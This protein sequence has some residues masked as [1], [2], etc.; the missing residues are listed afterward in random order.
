MRGR[1]TTWTRIRVNLQHVPSELRPAQEPLDPD[2]DPWQDRNARQ[3][4]AI[5]RRAEDLRELVRRRD[6]ELVVAAVLGRLSGRQRR[7]IAAWR[8]RCPAD[9]RT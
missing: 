5:R 1:F 8:K 9:G 4:A 3:R 7:K 6:L 2:Y